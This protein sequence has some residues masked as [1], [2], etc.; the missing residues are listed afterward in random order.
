MNKDKPKIWKLLGGL[1]NVFDCVVNLLVMIMS[2]SG[3]SAKLTVTVS[4]S[5]IHDKLHH[6]SVMCVAYSAKAPIVQYC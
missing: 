6:M 4:S 5:R 1:V 3:E 2:A